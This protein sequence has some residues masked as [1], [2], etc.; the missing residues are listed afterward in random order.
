MIY[1][2]KLSS[3]ISI[4]SFKTRL[5]EFIYL[6]ILSSILTVI[7]SFF[8]SDTFS[9]YIF[10]LS[11]SAVLSLT[12]IRMSN[13]MVY[14]LITGDLGMSVN[15]PMP[16]HTLDYKNDKDTIS[17]IFKDD[18]IQGILKLSTKPYGRKIKITT[19]KWM[20]EN[21]LC[22]N[23]VLNLFDIRVKKC[24]MFRI[25]KEVLFLVSD[26]SF[27]NYRDYISKSVF[28]KRE[29]YKI[30]LILKEKK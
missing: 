28:L 6:A 1:L 15:D 2:L 24:G 13:C 16:F 14:S 9:L 10:L 12:T 29:K 8:K 18:C 4:V 23:E 19:H 3:R 27:N 22:N 25:P 26:N 11:L 5:N 7:I 20:Y 17:R 21:V 30:I